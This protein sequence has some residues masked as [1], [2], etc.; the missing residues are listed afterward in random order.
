[1]TESQRLGVDLYELAGWS[2]RLFSDTERFELKGLYNRKPFAELRSDKVMRHIKK[3]VYDRGV[4]AGEKKVRDEVND[5]T[6][7]VKKYYDI[8]DLD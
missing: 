4:K 3:V 1:M 6:E 5:L 2:V 8:L 7:A